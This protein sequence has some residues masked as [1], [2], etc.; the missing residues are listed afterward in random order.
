MI[1]DLDTEPD[2][3]HVIKCRK[4][5][6]SELEEEEIKALRAFYWAAFYG[7]KKYVR[8]MIVDFKWSPF[9]KSWRKRSIL[10]AAIFGQRWRICKIIVEDFK[11][12]CLEEEWP[13]D[14]DKPKL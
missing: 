9:I 3:R 5:N 2:G 13:D 6:K 8:H 7:L 14:K 12:E 1:D 10:S 4:V 11:Y